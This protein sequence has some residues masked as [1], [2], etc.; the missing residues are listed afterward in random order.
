[1]A[2]HAQAERHA[3]ADLMLQVGPDAP[4]LCEGWKT[5]DL[6]AHLVTRERRPDAGIGLVLPAASSYTER[7][8]RGI[9]DGREWPDLVEMVRS[10]PPAPLRPL[11]ESINTVEYFIHHED[12]RRAQSGWEPRVL[13]A[14]LDQALWSRLRRMSRLLLLRA[15]GGLVLDAPGFGQVRKNGQANGVTVTGPPSELLLFASG[16]KDA[17]RVELAGDDVSVERIRQAKLGL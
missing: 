10:G 16:R 14:E 9:R 15:P 2:K 5:A 7:V 8:Q 3:L 6:A 12:V 4:T 13:G 1:M 11:D 17:A